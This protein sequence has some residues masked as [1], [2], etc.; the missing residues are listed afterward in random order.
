MT[1][2]QT[3]SL[4]YGADYRI[5]D[6]G[7]VSRDSFLSRGIRWFTRHWRFKNPAVSHVFVVTGEGRLIEANADGVELEPLS[8]YLGDPACTVYFRSVAAWTPELGARIAAGAMQYA[9]LKYDYDLILADAVSYSL[10]GRLVNGLT[11]D[12]LDAVLTDLATSKGAMICDQVAVTALQAVPSLRA[13]GTLRMPAARNNPQR[14]FGDDELFRPEVAMIRG[15]TAPNDG[16]SFAA[17][18]LRPA[19]C[20]VSCKRS[21]LIPQNRL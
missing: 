16:P 12:S 21:D 10:L 14:L 3:S 7:F 1:I 20:S 9:G 4:V 8:E 5:G 17:D 19:P 18:S 6:I 11:R 15:R 13:L 2:R